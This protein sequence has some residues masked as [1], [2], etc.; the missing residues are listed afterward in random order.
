MERIASRHLS[1]GR[2][3]SHGVLFEGDLDE[4]VFKILEISGGVLFGHGEQEMGGKRGDGGRG[5]DY[6]VRTAQA[7]AAV[8]V[9]RGP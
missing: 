9:C 8:S 4:R 7:G 3:C 6:I 1:V 5:R 2:R